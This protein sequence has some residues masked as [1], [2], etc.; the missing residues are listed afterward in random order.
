MLEETKKVGLESEIID[1][2]DFRIKATDNTGKIP[3]AKKLIDKIV[4]AD[5]YIIVAPEYNHGYPGEL[6]MMLDMFYS[7]YAKKPV[8]ICGVSR[9]PLGGA[10]MIQQLRQVCIAFNMVPLGRAIYF[11]NVWGLFDEK[12]NIKDESYYKKAKGLLDQLIWYAKALKKA[13]IL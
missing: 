2:R 9:G 11:S 13:P 6:K 1:V 4:K 5:G 7:Q 12:G 3:Q 8:G 10:R